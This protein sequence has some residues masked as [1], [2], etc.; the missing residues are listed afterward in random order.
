MM[1][2]YTPFRILRRFIGQTLE[3]IS[4]RLGTVRTL[5]QLPVSVSILKSEDEETAFTKVGLA[6][7]LISHFAPEKYKALKKD[8]ASIFVSD[9]IGSLGNYGRRLKSVRLRASYVTDPE[10]THQ[11]IACCLI[12]EA[13]HG[14]LYR[15]GFGYDDAVRTR[16]ERICM[17][18]ERNFAR[19][20][21]GC[22]ALVADL[23]D[24]LDFD[25]GPHISDEAIWRS[26]VEARIKLL[27]DYNVPGWLVRFAERRTNRRS[28]KS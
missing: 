26:N 12:H 7:D 6:L 3:R 13:Q 1:R 8:V 16:I 19:R 17:I 27:K 25:W 14:R 9:A 10:T 4:F 18:A 28:K 5:H 21:P 24:R 11:A 20:L 22:A 2:G 15:L 23:E